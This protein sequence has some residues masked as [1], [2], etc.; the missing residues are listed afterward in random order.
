MIEWAVA[1]RCLSGQ[2]ES[3]DAYAAVT[4]E[5]GALL[6]VVDGLGHGH[7]AAIAS[8]AAVAALTADPAADLV[9][10]M[11]RCHERLIDTR[12]AVI[13]LAAVHER[14]R[15]L[16]WLGVGDAAGVVARATFSS[17][18][19]DSL[20]L[21]PGIVGH[22]LPALSSEV[23]PFFPGDVLVMATDGIRSAFMDSVDAGGAPQEL[24][25]RLLADFARGYDDA[26]VLAAR[27]VVV[28]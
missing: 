3:G 10:L 21:K 26:L 2:D 16:T 20:S 25:D 6:A 4:F 7:E 13:A 11:T 5:G 24:A 8:R 27:Y 23:V 17:P 28:P 1:L 12:G 18:Q 14:E 9:T 22:R 19:R 15:S